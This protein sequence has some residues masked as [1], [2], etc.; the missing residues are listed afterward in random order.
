MLPDQCC[1][2]HVSPTQSMHR[3]AEPLAHPTKPCALLRS[4]LFKQAGRTDVRAAVQET[5]ERASRQSAHVAQS[6][7]QAAQEGSRDP[8]E[9]VRRGID[10]SRQATEAVTAQLQGVGTAPRSLAL[11]LHANACS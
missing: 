5:L 6:L 3:T 9:A 4:P 10:G 2:Q 8:A 7:Q 1:S 11:P